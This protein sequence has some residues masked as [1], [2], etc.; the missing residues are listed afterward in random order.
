MIFLKKMKLNKNFKSYLAGLIEGDGSF[1]VPPQQRDLKG[2][3]LYPKVKVVFAKKDQPLADLLNN[4]YGGN[5]EI[6]ENYIVWIIVKKSQILL[7]CEH[8]NGYLRTLKINDLSKLINFLKVRDSSIHLNVLPLNETPINS[9]SWL[10][11]FSE[12]DGNFHINITKRKNNKK[13]VQLLYRLEIKQFFNGSIIKNSENYSSFLPVCN[14]I[15]EHF[16]LGLYHRT[17]KKKYHLIIVSTTSVRTNTKVIEYFEKFPLF[18]SKY[19][20][21]VNWKTIHKMQEKKLHL[22]SEGLEICETIKQNHNN[23]RTRFSWDHLKNFYL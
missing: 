14:T 13:R 15:A 1:I 4:Y 3:L 23:N 21:Y 9:D 19:L 17:R 12:A 10:A 8:I 11:G 2:R 18:S 7:I 6:H 5:F 16:N 20:D 22:T